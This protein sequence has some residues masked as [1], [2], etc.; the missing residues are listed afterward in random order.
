MVCGAIKEDGTRIL[1]RCPDLMNSAVY[2]EVLKK[3]LL[4]MYDPRN[5]FQ[6]NGAPCHKSRWVT[7]FLDKANICVLSPA[8]SPDLNAIELLWR[9]LKAIVSSC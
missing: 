8:Q 9:N 4:T 6:Q 5:I 2:E 7:T 3:G 1:R